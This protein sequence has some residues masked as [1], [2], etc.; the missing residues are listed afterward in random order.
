LGLETFHFF[1]GELHRA[2]D[3]AE[4]CLPLAQ[5]VHDP[6]RL[7]QAHLALGSTLF[8]LGELTSAREHLEQGM[9]FY[10]PQQY[11]SR[12]FRALQDPG[13]ACLSYVAWILWHLGYPE[14]ALQ[15]STEMLTLARER[16]HPF[17]LA[18]AL[19]FAARLHQ[20]R[21]EWQ[22]AQER[23]E[24]AIVISTE[25]GFPHWLAWGTFMR[26]WAQTERG[27]GEEGIVQMR[28]GLAAWRS[29]GGK[30]YGYIILPCWP[31]RM[32]K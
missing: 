19:D 26:G 3:L 6:A 21:R 9:A 16:S 32:G 23:A 7:L 24:A 22:A 30:W 11:R 1:R 27:E 25:Q 10:D 17:S 2:Y 13:V 20:Y 5:R 28:Q 29:T 8:H 15:R 4:Q 31:K 14:Q 12:A 18:N